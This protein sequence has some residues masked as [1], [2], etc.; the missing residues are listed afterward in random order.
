MNREKVVRLLERWWFGWL[1]LKWVRKLLVVDGI[2]S[3]KK[4]R[5]KHERWPTSLHGMASRRRKKTFTSTHI[6]K[7]LKISKN[8]NDLLVHVEN[9]R[10]YTRRYTPIFIII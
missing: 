4:E 1:I 6:Q 3:R 9:K 5:K 8:Y 7:C 10:V 2:G